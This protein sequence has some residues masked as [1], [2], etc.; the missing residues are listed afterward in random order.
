[1][2]P[3]GCGKSTLFRCLAGLTPYQQGQIFWQDSAQANLSGQIALMQQKDLLLPWLSLRSNVELPARLAGRAGSDEA[4]RLLELMGLL[5]DSHK[6]PSALSGG[7]RQRGALARTLM[8]HLPVM[9]LDEPLSA[10]DALTRRSLWQTLKEL[11]TCHGLTVL[12]ITH[13]LEEALVLGDKIVVLSSSPMKINFTLTL[14]HCPGLRP[15][16]AD[17]LVQRRLLLAHLEGAAS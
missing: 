12:M 15:L 5:E 6:L 10:L 1:M 11:Q 2:G 17:L 9:L 4:G 7:M 16:D 8:M 13:D 14:D 3:S